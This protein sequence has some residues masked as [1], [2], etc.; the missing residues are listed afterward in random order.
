MKKS[1]KKNL[2]RMKWYWH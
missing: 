2:K 1:T